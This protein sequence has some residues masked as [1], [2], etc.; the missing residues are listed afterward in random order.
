MLAIRDPRS[1]TPL[2]FPAGRSASTIRVAISVLD[3]G[4]ARRLA[5]TLTLWDDLGLESRRSAANEWPDA[6]VVLVDRDVVTPMPAVRVTEAIRAEEL[7]AA[8]RAAAA[9]ELSGAHESRSLV[10]GVWAVKGGCGASVFAVNLAAAVRLQGL[11]VAYADLD[12][13][14]ADGLCWFDEGPPRDLLPRA[15]EHPS[16]LRGFVA[17]SPEDP[18]PI[19]AG[20]RTGF[21]LSVIDLPASRLPG[22]E[23]D[24]LDLLYVLVPCDLVSLRRARRAWGLLPGPVP[25]RVV[26]VERPGARIGPGDIDEVLE[27]ATEAVLVHEPAVAEWTDRGR[28]IHGYRRSRWAREVRALAGTLVADLTEEGVS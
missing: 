6:D 5:T 25:T 21:D 15:L 19:V 23:A 27:V 22:P 20:L 10:V 9:T 11:S 4:F 1:S 17:R 28:L 7:E 2:T 18:E 24:G 16:G 14:W 12:F 8:I 13:D 26:A 3:S